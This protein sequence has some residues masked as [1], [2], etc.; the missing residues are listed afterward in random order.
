VSSLI[1]DVS[2]FNLDLALGGAIPAL[3]A[4]ASDET[5]LTAAG[6]AERHRRATS[7]APA[8][9]YNRRVSSLW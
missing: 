7:C 5:T 4:D 3:R 9:R 8:S 1:A 2:Q 6:P